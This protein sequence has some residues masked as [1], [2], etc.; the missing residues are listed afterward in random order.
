MRPEAE[1]Q[2]QNRR[3]YPTEEE[4]LALAQRM[5]KLLGGKS[6]HFDQIDDWAGLA[7]D[8]WEASDL[9]WEKFVKVVEWA[10]T[11]NEYTVANL[12]ISRD[13][14]KSLF[15]N[16][17]ENVQIFYDAAMAVKVAVLRKKGKPICLVC[18]MAEGW[19]VYDGMCEECRA[20]WKK[21]Y[22]RLSE[23]LDALV[24]RKLYSRR[25][26]QESDNVSS[27]LKSKWTI[28]WGGG[29]VPAIVGYFASFDD[30]DTGK[31]RD[32]II[33]DLLEDPKML[34]RFEKVWEMVCGLE[35]IPP[36][37][38]ETVEALV[39]EPGFDV[40]DAE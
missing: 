32:R 11:E 5:F 3:R 34:E 35:S 8:A 25:A 24:E 36:D 12:R 1:E 15:V 16:Q 23:I 26:V 28:F 33:R 40:E 30:Q 22:Q 10:L 27:H 17:W 31:R 19:R 14:G 2:K 4:G 39:P 9:T 7:F 6:R 29:R 20:E 38:V 18:E 37:A 21:E 13:P